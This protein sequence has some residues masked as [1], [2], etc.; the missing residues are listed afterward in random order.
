MQG[1]RNPNQRDARSVSGFMLSH[2]S[3]AIWLCEFS[4]PRRN[5]FREPEVHRKREG[6]CSCNIDTW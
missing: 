3:P 6:K 2:Q 5:P 1:H 4:L